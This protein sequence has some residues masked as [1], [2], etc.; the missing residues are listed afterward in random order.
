VKGAV[1]YRV[2]PTSPGRYLEAA[3]RR[4]GVELLVMDGVLDWDRI[5][6]DCSFVVVVESP[7][8][9]LEVRGRKPRVPTLFW[10]HHGEHHLPA[11]LR[12]TYR[13]QADAVLMAHSWHLAHRF[14]VSTHR[15]PFGFPSE[16][17]TPFKT[18]L[19]R[20]HDVAMVGAG[21]GGTGRRYDRRREIVDMIED[22]ESLSAKMAYGLKPQEM[23][24]VYG[25]ARI[26]LNDGG[27]RHLPITM[28][29]FEALGAGALLLTEDIPG[30]ET[31]LRRGEHYVP[32]EEDVGTQARNLLKTEESSS[33]AAAGHDWVMSRH[34]YDHRVD[35]LL[36]LAGG[37]E[38]DTTV[39][40]PF[41]AKTSMAALIDQDVDVQTVAVFGEA[42]GLT[43]RDRAVRPGYVDKLGEKTID[44]VVIGRGDIPDIEG[45]VAAAR[46]YVYSSEEHV[47]D[48]SGIL[49]RLRPDAASAIHEGM[50]RAD[51][52]G[53]PYRT[54]P[55][56]HPLSS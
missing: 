6:P 33:I 35:R 3:L 32:M 26:V 18:W 37:I 25:D 9:A 43:G 5:D 47:S 20:T 36:A 8:P 15:F 21:I 34:T 12:L 14:P 4:A 46:G 11:N 7:Y 28:R 24:S 49:E 55:A 44:A 16:M 56:D 23:I 13:Y 42:D 10:V 45:A 27:P 30:T 53:S 40:S 38:P 31:I 51:L 41:P 22:D 52:G 17:T 50:L 1:A 19:E 2:S 54:R 48:V 29:V 39:R